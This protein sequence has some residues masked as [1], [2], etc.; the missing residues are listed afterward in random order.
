MTFFRKLSV[1]NKFSITFGFILL[2]LLILGISWQRGIVSLQKIE[3]KTNELIELKEKL[4]ELQM[5]HY[6]WVDELREAVRKR[7][8]FTGELDPEKC[9]FGQWY[10]SF[11]VPN[12]ELEQLYRALEEPHKKLHEA[13]AA[14]Q[15]AINQGNFGEAER[16]S[17][18]VRQSFLPELM[19][20]YD[21]FMAGIGELYKTYKLQS[22]TSVKRQNVTSKTIL[23][24]SVLAVI[25]AGIVLTRGIVN[26]L[27]RVTETAHKIA[28]GEFPDV[29]EDET[30]YE[31]RNEIVQM[32]SAF[33]RMAISLNDLSRT[34]DRIASGDLEAAVTIRSDEDILGKA[35]AQMVENLK[36][37]VDD[38]H[39]N[40]MNLALGMSDYFNII[41]ELSVGNLDVSASED[42]GDELLDQLGK[43]T[44]N[45]IAEY[46]KLYECIED[47]TKGNMEVEVHI[48]SEKDVLAIG[49]QNMLQHLKEASEELHGSSMNLAMGL[50]DYF[51]ILQQV[52]EG[53]LTVRASEETGD[54]LLNQLGKATNSMI[55]SLSDLTVKV[56]EQGDFL[57]SSANA[58]ATVS[59]QS[60]RA[61]TELSSAISLISSAT[62]SVA[63][64]SQGASNAAQVANSS[65]IKGS[66]LML[67][68][69]E[70][71]KMLQ[72]ANERSVK[73]MKDLSERSSEIGKIVNVMTKI[74]FQTNLLSLN[75]AIE[76]ARAGESGH[77]FAVVADEVRKLAESSADS[78]RE[79]SKIVK[80]VQDETQEAM[81][82]TQEAEREMESG[83]QLIEEVSLQFAEIASQVESIVTQISNIATSSTDTASSASEA[84]ASS[85]QQTAAIEELAASAAQLSSTADILRETMA[86]FKL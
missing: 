37:S 19:K 86:R 84:S 29:L 41:T 12:A 73:A 58:L 70:K 56:R 14:V 34:A 8:K 45:M 46:Q 6:R 83:V 16:L 3:G 74:A 52:A 24:L 7:Q 53:D 23:I 2:V 72:E 48:R 20:I 69:A 40:S 5:I 44:N 71:T 80:E 30:E 61:L 77:G 79:I 1:G 32:E 36:K 64:N 28:E 75:A 4:R 15:R 26:P 11:V 35:I 25:A 81:L 76:A 17:L 27:Q 51:F 50:T 13:G 22:M 18:R 10:Y 33:R 38:L 68:L 82:S 78:A 59:K 55:V 39:N 60:T 42:T 66:D 49:F 63:D 65:T 47:I 21:P 43:V 9:L 54:D 31:T 62:S 57:A 67:K 85:E